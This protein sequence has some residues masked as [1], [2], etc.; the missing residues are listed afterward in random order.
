MSWNESTDCCTSDGV[1]CDMLKGHIIGLDLSDRNIYGSIHPNNSLFQLRHLQTLNLA[2]NNFSGPVP[3]SICNLT[4]IRELSFGENHFTSHI[5]STISKLKQLKLLDL[6]SNS[7]GGEIPDGLLSSSICNMSILSFLDLSRNNFSNSIPS[8][9]GSIAS[10]TVLDLRRNHFSGS[11]TPLYTQKT[12]LTTI[13]NGNR[14]EGHVPM[15]LLNCVRLEFLDI[16]N[17]AINDTF[18]TWIGTLEELQVLILKSNNFHGPISTRLKVS[19]PRLRIFDL[20]HNEF[21]GSLPV[22]VF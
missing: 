16:G 21:N 12:S 18:P 17:N 7:L 8:F 9:L 14:F 6:S 13:L 10:L 22:E 3:R 15:S 4:Q 11:L 5:P 19:F 20:S 2:Y 1:T